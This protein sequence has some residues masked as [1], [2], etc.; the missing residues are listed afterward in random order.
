V[1]VVAAL[2]LV[3]ATV[4]AFAFR[5]ADRADEQTVTAEANARVARSHEL[6]AAAVGAVDDDPALAKLLAVSAAT[7]APMGLQTM[8]ALHQVWAADATVARSAAPWG[9]SGWF[10]LDPDGDRMARSGMW[11]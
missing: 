11:F 3:A 8:S 2:A 10:A 9:D 7:S 6:A 5:E 1:A 4:G